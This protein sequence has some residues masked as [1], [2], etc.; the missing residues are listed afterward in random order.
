M[1]RG[2][3]KRTQINSSWMDIITASLMPVLQNMKMGNDGKECIEKQSAHSIPPLPL[4]ALIR[5]HT[6]NQNGHLAGTQPV[7]ESNGSEVL[8][9]SS[10][11]F[12]CW[13]GWD[14]VH[15]APK[16]SNA[17]EHTEQI[18]SRPRPS[19]PSALD[20]QRLGRCVP[21]LKSSMTD[22]EWFVLQ[23]HSV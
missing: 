21:A 17:A 14:N 23:L 2:I 15:A 1:Q 8:Q 5:K 3:T 13:I 16:A 11:D 20:V 10:S 4:A 22:L 6:A 9:P 12:T 7:R 19:L 18:C